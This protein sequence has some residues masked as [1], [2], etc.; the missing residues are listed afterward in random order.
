VTAFG[1]LAV[2]CGVVAPLGRVPWVWDTLEHVPRAVTP[3]GSPPCPLRAVTPQDLSPQGCD[4]LCVP[5]VSP[6]AVTPWG[7][8]LGLVTPQDGSP[9]SVTPFWVPTMSPGAVTPQ[10]GSLGL[11]TPQ[12]LSPLRAVTSWA[13][14]LRLVTPFVLPPHCVP[15]GL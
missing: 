12:D 4:T 11:V 7:V 14:S 10:D 1:D 8:S 13:V 2:S 3:F 15:S 9:E 5:I 6:G